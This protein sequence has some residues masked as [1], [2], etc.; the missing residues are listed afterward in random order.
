MKSNK[1]ISRK[2]FFIKFHFLQFQK[3]PKINFWTGKKLKTARNAILQINN[4]IYLISRVFMP[5]LFLNFLACCEIEDEF[6]W[7]AFL[8]NW[9]QTDDDEKYIID[10]SQ[11]YSFLT[12]IIP[13]Y[14]IIMHVTLWNSIKL[15]YAIHSQLI[16]KSCWFQTK[17]Q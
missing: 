13:T 9:N 1:S 12:I 16:W 11:N 15:K 5:G 4:L 8:W 17:S 10:F 3:W 7:W 14:M 6:W 2:N